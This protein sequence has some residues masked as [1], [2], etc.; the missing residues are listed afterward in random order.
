[1]RTLPAHY[2][3]SAD[4]LDREFD[5]EALYTA[6]YP[7]IYNYF[8][9]RVGPD[10]AEDLTAITFER[11]WRHRHRYRRDL[12]AF[13][14]W[15]FGIARKVAAHHLRQRKP[16]IALDDVQDGLA[17]PDPPV[18]HAIQQNAEAEQLAA[19][20]QQLPDRDRELIALK[21]GSGLTNRAIARQTG[22][23][24]T[25]VGSILYRVVRR[26]RAEW[27]DIS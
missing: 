19:L 17:A 18:E 13:E 10:E 8:R 21:Y 24:E 26:L 3:M 4:K 27:D 20:L 7:R 14:A 9:F 6:C 16:V 1:M 11:A 23:S 22:L 25:N 15:L 12:G 5:W 2:S